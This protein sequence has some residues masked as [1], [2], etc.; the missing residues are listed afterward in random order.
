MGG[1]P[2]SDQIDAIQHLMC[3]PSKNCHNIGW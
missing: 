2:A 3:P 1:N